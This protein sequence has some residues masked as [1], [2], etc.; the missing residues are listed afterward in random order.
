MELFKGATKESG[1]E[2]PNYT[3]DQLETIDKLQS[4]GHKI[5]FR[6][7]MFAF[8][9]VV[10]KV[11]GANFFINDRGWFGWN[12]ADRNGNVSG[13]DFDCLSCREYQIKDLI[14]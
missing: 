6:G 14:T 8:A 11:C 5:M 2:V 1:V 9:A 12:D 4:L 10:C 3:V 7:R 13:Q